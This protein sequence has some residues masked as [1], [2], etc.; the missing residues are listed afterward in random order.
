MDSF[1]GTLQHQV[2][3][4]ALIIDREQLLFNGVE[5]LRETI[6]FSVKGGDGL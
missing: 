1:T 6:K 5:N 3:A 4:I 2:C